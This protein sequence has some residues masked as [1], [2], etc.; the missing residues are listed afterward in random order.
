MIEFDVHQQKKL[1]GGTLIMAVKESAPS[2]NPTIPYEQYIS[3][4]VFNKEREKIFSKNWILVGH[5]SQVKNAGDFFTFEVAGEPIIVTHCTDG[6]LHAFYNICPH[7]GA[8]VERSEQG[9]KKILQCSYHGWTF[10]L[11]GH[12]HRAPNFKTNELGKH[13]CMKSIRLE[14]HHSLIFVNLDSDAPSFPVAYQ[15]FLEEMQRYSFLESLKLVRET[16]RIVKANWK[17]VID[18]FLECDH[19]PIA[20]PGFAKTFDLSNYN[21]IIDNKFSY[22]CS[23]VSEDTEGASARFYWIWPNMML[24]VYPGAGNVN[25]IQVVPIDAE[26]S[27]GIYRDYSVDA[28][29]TKEKEE[30]FTF[31]DQV[32]EEDFDLVEVLQSGFR[33]KA[34]ENGIYSPTEHAM[35]HFHQMIEEALQDE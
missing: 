34:F 22:Q 4:Q 9:N 12:V 17:A 15:S 1:K 8:K 13:S 11:D 10:K 35:E 31:V 7:R 32:R 29:L 14:V 21:I 23:T 30:L 3:P 16:R 27:L 28:E 18:N 2:F 24:N 6:E 33:S 26:T 20:H 19:C 25:T 5:T